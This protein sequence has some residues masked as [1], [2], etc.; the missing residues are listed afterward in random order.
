[1]EECLHQG[2]LIPLHQLDELL[3]DIPHKLDPINPKSFVAFEQLRGISQHLL[4]HH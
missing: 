3:A 4:E 2:Q 1:M